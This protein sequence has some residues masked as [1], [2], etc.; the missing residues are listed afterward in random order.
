VQGGTA[1]GA[2]KQ[3]QQDK[4]EALHRQK[5]SVSRARFRTAGDERRRPQIALV[6]RAS[7]GHN[8]SAS[9]LVSTKG[10]FNE[11]E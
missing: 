3:G 1:A 5:D 7:A 10:S 8:P 6:V 4:D 9:F 11:M 2:G